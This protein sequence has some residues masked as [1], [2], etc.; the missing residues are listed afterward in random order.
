MKKKRRFW[1]QYHFWLT[2]GSLFL[3][4]VLLGASPVTAQS[5]TLLFIDPP[6]SQVP[7]G[8]TITLKVVVTG[9]NDVNAF[10]VTVLYDSD[11]LNLASW[12]KGDFLSNLAVVKEEDEPGRL[13]IA[14]TQLATP[15]VSGDGVLLLLHFETKSTG[16]AKIDL[17][18]VFLADPAGKMNTPDWEHGEVTVTNDPTYTP[19]TTMTGT[20]TPTKPPTSSS[21]PTVT[22][23]PKQ[24]EDPKD[25]P[26]ATP[27]AAATNVNPTLQNTAVPTRTAEEE[28]KTPLH[29]RE[30]D[31]YPETDTATP[32]TLNGDPV[33]PTTTKKASGLEPVLVDD[34]GGNPPND[35]SGSSASLNF[36]S[37]KIQVD[38]VNLL[39]WSILIAGLVAVVIMIFILIQQ[40]KNQEEDLLL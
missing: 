30:T 5:E 13:W 6:M 17:P 14:A 2:I 10:D 35:R 8:N 36:F 38:G 19:T 28:K 24:Y 25:D 39:L 20:A 37:N 15:P 3:M 16:L 4:A 29:T 11:R 26:T 33:V 9:G 40:S 22:P 21:T 31:A 7:L 32:D 18:K 23:T 1:S 12:E 27:T 34:K